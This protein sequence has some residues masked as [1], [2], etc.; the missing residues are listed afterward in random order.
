MELIDL[1]KNKVWIF[2]RGKNVPKAN[3][4]NLEAWFNSDPESDFDNHHD[5][6]QDHD[7]DLDYDL[8]RQSNPYI[9]GILGSR[10]VHLC[11]LDPEN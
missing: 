4:K 9:S 11:D 2:G 6:S 1:L 10:K 7:L 3:V 5:L 8:I